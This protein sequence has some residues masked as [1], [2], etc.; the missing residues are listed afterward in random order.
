MRKTGK[1]PVADLVIMCLATT[2]TGNPR[3]P[4]SA[5]LA[6][7]GHCICRFRSLG[8]RGRREARWVLGSRTRTANRYRLLS[9]QDQ[10][11]AVRDFEVPMLDAKSGAYL[12]SS[13]QA[14]RAEHEPSA[15]ETIAR[16]LGIVRR[17]I[18]LVLVFALL[19][20][21]LAASMS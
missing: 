18:F 17:Q 4:V 7:G 6:G 21:L 11:S 2:Q 8:A 5:W 13:E 1:A 20:L 16:G 19:G 15:A 10:R 9:Y 14:P 12:L 3:R